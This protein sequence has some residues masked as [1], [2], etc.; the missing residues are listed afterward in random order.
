L[1]NAGATDQ[2][3]AQA[4]AN[5]LATPRRKR[6]CSLPSNCSYKRPEPICPTAAKIR[7]A[8]WRG[9]SAEVSRR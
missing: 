3:I 2:Q 7:F 8:R 6:S 4:W 9:I 5:G 1:K